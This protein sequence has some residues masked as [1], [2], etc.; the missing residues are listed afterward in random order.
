MPRMNSLA[1]VLLALAL[2]TLINAFESSAGGV[3]LDI[4]KIPPL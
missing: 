3:K 4:G 1:V 2:P